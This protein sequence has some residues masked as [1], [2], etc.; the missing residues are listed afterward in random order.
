MNI[1]E[2]LLDKFKLPAYYLECGAHD[3]IGDS[4]TLQLEKADWSGLL[5]EPSSYFYGLQRSGRKC[6]IDNR[7]LWSRSNEYVNFTE[8]QGTELSGITD[9]FQDDKWD[10][11][12][13]S[14]RTYQVRTVSL[15]D[16]LDEHNAPKII[17]FMC[18]DTEGS[19]SEILSTYDISRHR[20]LVMMV[21][22]NGVESQRSKIL[23]ILIPKGY[24]LFGDD[25]TNLVM[26]YSKD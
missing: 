25:I 12:K 7:A 16:L 20:I 8:V 21:E 18:L 17:Q 23:D 22:Y 1:Q 3:G 4:Q 11:L 13:R 2:Y 10:R 9:T 5:V 6:K 26:V 14:H 15:N 19:E 24:E